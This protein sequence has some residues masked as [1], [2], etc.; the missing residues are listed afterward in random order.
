MT[1]WVRLR[2]AA[3]VRFY[4]AG[5]ARTLLRNPRWKVDIDRI[6]ALSDPGAIGEIADGGIAGV[7]NRRL[8]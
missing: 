6:L 3:V 7:G 2:P 4:P 8:P 1:S 5:P